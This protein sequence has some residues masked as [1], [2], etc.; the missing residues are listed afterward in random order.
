MHD[1][2]RCSIL[3]SM[4]EAEN[5]D[6]VWCVYNDQL[7]KL[8][9]ENINHQQDNNLKK[10]Y[11]KYLAGAQNNIGYLSKNQGN[12]IK[13]LEYYHKSLKI[14]EGINDKPGIANSLNNLGIVYRSQGDLIKALE[15][16][17][18]GLKLYEEIHDQD[19][20]ATSLNN[21]AIIYDIKGNSKQALEY[22]M[23]SLKIRE[24]IDDEMGMA[25]SLINIGFIYQNREK[26]PQT[27]DF[28]NRALHIYEDIKFKSGISMALYYIGTVF[29]KQGKVNEAAIFAQRCLVVAKEAD[30]PENIRNAAAL[31]KEIYKK[32]GNFRG[33]LL[34]YE[35]Q[36]Q[37]RDSIANEETKKTSI[38]KQYQYEYEK[39]AAA[40]SVKNAEE[41]KVKNAKLVAQQ[42]QLKQEK[43]QRFALYGGLALVVLFL[44]FVFNRF[45]IIQGQ[46]LIIEN[47]KKDVDEAFKH[48]EEKNK[49]VMDSITYAQRIQRALITSEL[50][51]EKQLN[52]LSKG[53]S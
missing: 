47:Q 14:Q 9:E 4:I 31:L 42:A 7:L 30:F 28:Y 41:Q 11:L 5:E 15:Y 24:D 19:G 50:Y 26:I 2:T 34:M 29:L 33:S 1:T 36:I 43:T 6:K 51:I 23:K 8:A 39:K 53:N 37:M 10:F 16:H 35:L 17:I 12:I 13:A 48:L 21:I 18:R 27:L 32:Q 44:A 25:Q 46:K 22:F 20:I 52:R 45:K 40:D 38:K 49:E 3:N